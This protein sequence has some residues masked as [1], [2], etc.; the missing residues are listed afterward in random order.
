[1]SA[2]ILVSLKDTGRVVT[3]PTLHHATVRLMLNVT[4]KKSEVAHDPRGHR[5]KGAALFLHYRAELVNSHF[6][7]QYYEEKYYIIILFVLTKNCFQK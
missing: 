1:M 7:V 3:P 4:G 5:S 2:N 6:I